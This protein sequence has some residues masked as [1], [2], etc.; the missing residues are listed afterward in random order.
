MSFVE[1]ILMLHCDLPVRVMKCRVKPSQSVNDKPH[2]PWIIVKE[3]GEVWSAHCTCKAG[4]VHLYF[5]HNYG[6][7]E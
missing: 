7:M 5:L 1:T 6:P 2:E 3:S 4:Y